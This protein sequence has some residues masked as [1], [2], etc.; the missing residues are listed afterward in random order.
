MKQE[1]WIEQL[2]DKL[3]D[4]EMAAPEGLWEDI[5]AALPELLQD[6]KPQKARFATLRRWAVA[7]SL[8]ALIATSGYWWYAS[9]GGLA[10]EA[11]PSEPVPMTGMAGERPMPQTQNKEKTPAPKISVT[12]LPLE[13]SASKGKPMVSSSSQEALT[14]EETTSPQETPTTEKEAEPEMSEKAPQH[15]TASRDEQAIV[16]QLEQQIAQLH[17]NSNKMPA[18]SLYAMNGF[19]NQSN[20]NGV[21][22]SDN[23]AQ[24]FVNPA[25]YQGR[26][27]RR[28][29]TIYLAGYEERQKHYQPIS[30]GLTVSYPL[31]PRLSLS[32]G[33]VFT[34][35]QSDFVN[36]RPGIQLSRKQQ[37]DYLGIPLTMGY[38]M[39][40]YKGLK[41]YLSTGFQADW[42]IHTSLKTQGVDQHLDKD[43]MQWSVSGALGVQYDIIPQ[44]GLYAEPGIRYYFD[45]GSSLQNFFKDK[46]TNFSLQ[47]G[48]RLN[49]GPVI[50]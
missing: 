37:L 50:F 27:A 23:L 16:Q 2:R 48:L 14:S 32:T 42:N 30:F 13:A 19:G 29:E 4:H 17:S 6:R 39:W 25:D 35:L 43:R 21:I 49:L 40:S 31:S 8:V 22:M 5:E 1:K 7:A 44:I 47:V 34:H 11:E 9:H 38:K 18:L 20:S 45:N 41:T 46:P 33:I 3:A 28:S 12:A 10:P 24:N 15:E 26:L 36:I